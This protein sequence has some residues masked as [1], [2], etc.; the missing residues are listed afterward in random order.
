MHLAFAPTAFV[1]AFLALALAACGGGSEADEAVALFDAHGQPSAEAR[2]RPEG[3]P[4]TKTGLFATPAQ[5]AWEALTAE[6]YTVLVDLDTAASPA[7]ALAIA[8]ANHA[9]A[10][11]Q[12]HVGVAH[13]VRGG[14]CE[15]AVTVVDALSA[16]GVGPV[17]LVACRAR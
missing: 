6:P 2:H 7:D 4:A 17:F 15:A 9:F 16:G 5:Y 1:S 8:R 13:F 10:T 12:R 3:S 14:S 11:A